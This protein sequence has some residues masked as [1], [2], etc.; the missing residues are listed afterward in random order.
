MGS[1]KCYYMGGGEEMEKNRKKKKKV[2]GR[3]EIKKGKERKR[4]IEVCHRKR[5]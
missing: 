5:T 1:M 3:I 4:V 2:E